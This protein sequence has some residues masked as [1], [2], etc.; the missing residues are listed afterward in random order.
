MSYPFDW[1]KVDKFNIILDIL[2][3]KF[4]IFF[5]NYELI[6]QSDNFNKFD[7]F[8][9]SENNIKS[10]IKI[11]LSNNIILP[12]EAN[13]FT[14]DEIGYKEKYMRRIKRFDAVISNE[15]VKKIFI[16]CDNKKITDANKELL[17]KS[18]DNYGCVN[19]EIYYITY[20]DYV[21][22]GDFTWKRDY[23]D[24]VTLFNK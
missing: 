6:E 4:S 22:N 15:N 19:Y 18:L 5:E 2:Q 8:E 9:H 21:C 12:H 17:T 3:S 1:A 16:R 14:F 13:G 11:K 10:R 23:I 24:W 20:S 7:N